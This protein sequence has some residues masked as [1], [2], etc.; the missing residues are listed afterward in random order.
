MCDLCFLNDIHPAVV[1]IGAFFVG[2]T[3]TFIGLCIGTWIAKH[4]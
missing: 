3:V 2:G 1:F 4:L